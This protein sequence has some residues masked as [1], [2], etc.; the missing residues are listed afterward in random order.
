MTL[1]YNPFAPV[2]AAFVVHAAT[3][4]LPNCRQ[5]TSLTL[6]Y[7]PGV[8]TSLQALRQWLASPNCAITSLTL[9]TCG[10]TYVGA[11]PLAD[12]IIR[13][14]TLTALDLSGNVLQDAGLRVLAEA[15]T[16]S[17]ATAESRLRVL[18]LRHNGFSA[19]EDTAEL[20]RRLEV[21][22][23]DTRPKVAQVR[24]RKSRGKG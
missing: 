13:C 6:R 9:A 8:Q 18:D 7:L 5:L 3:A 24:E 23:T 20:L 15:M 2:L 17:T 16:S 11:R 21:E 22:V 14:T 10:I 12:G 4:A 19:G 1:V